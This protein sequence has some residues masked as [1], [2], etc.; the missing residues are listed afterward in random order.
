MFILIT[1]LAQIQWTFTLDV[2]P[3]DKMSIIIDRILAEINHR[4]DPQKDI[5]LTKQNLSF[6]YNIKQINEGDFGKSLKELNVEKEKT[7]FVHIKENIEIEAT[8]QN[9]SSNVAAK[10]RKYKVMDTTIQKIKDDIKNEPN[11]VTGKY[12]LMYVGEILEDKD[13]NK[14]LADFF[15]NTPIFLFVVEEK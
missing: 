12:K 9:L 6:I 1:V 2:S 13:N 4:R 14:T 10:K 11:F 3:E 7:I 15:V 8:I 5:I